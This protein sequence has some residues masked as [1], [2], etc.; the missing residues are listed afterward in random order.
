MIES[1]PPFVPQSALFSLIKPLL[2]EGILQKIQD[3]YL[4]WSELKYKKTKSATPEQLW[5]AVKLYRLLNQRT[6]QFGNYHF[7]YVLTDYIQQALHNFDMHIEGTLTSNMGIAEV[8]THK[9]AK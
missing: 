1:P 4:Y 7:S 5:Q 6:L 3:E 8:D 9:V 2:E